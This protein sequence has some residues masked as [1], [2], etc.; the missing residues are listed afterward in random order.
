MGLEPRLVWEHFARLSMIPRC[1]GNE[2]AAAAHVCGIA[3]TLGCE[4]LRDTFGNVLA[5]KKAAPDCQKKPSVVLQSHLDMVG[6]KNAGISHDFATDPIVLKRQGGFITA[7]NTTLGADNGIGVATALAIMEDSSLRHGPLEFLFTVEEETGLTGAANLTKGFLRSRMLINLDSEEEGTV[8]VGCAGGGDTVGTIPISYEPIPDGFDILTCKVAGLRGGHSGLEIHTGRGNAIKLLSRAVRLLADETGARLCSMTGGN[9]RNA[10]PREAEAV[11]AVPRSKI[12][13]ADMLAKKVNASFTEEYCGIDDGVTVTMQTVESRESPV[14]SKNDQKKIL[15]CIDALPHG[16]LA[17]SK[18]IPDLVETSSNLA[19]IATLPDSVVIE[20][21]QRS[22]IESN[23]NGVM[24]SAAD[25]F[26]K[27]G[28]R[29]EHGDGY[30]G[31]KPDLSS[32]ILSVARESYLALF[33]TDARVEAIHAGL[34]CGL[35]VRKY[36]D[37]DMISIGPTMH[38]VHSPEERVDIASVKRFWEFLA[39]ILDRVC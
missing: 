36:P 25:I 26:T 21:S 35:V 8:V 29:V 22:S 18:E 23:K 10:I 27:A 17:M 2:A 6:E 16:V 15:D 33:G 9:K 1:S 4:V 13:L 24:S 34:E 37:M 5:R 32:P 39:G 7:D 3:A 20:T 14:I 11:I 30:P 19:K 28:A 12:G 38:M 31:W